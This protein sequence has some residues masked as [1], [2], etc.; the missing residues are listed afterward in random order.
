MLIYIAFYFVPFFIVA[1][2]FTLRAWKHTSSLEITFT[3]NTASTLYMPCVNIF[4]YNK[5]MNSREVNGTENIIV[6]LLQK[7]EIA[8][9]SNLN[10]GPTYKLL[11]IFFL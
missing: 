1:S 7:K 9:V 10:T 8:L 4:I 2:H 6:F 5:D 3:I 11:F